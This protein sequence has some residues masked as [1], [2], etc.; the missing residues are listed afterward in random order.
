MSSEFEGYVANAVGWARAHLGSTEYSLRCLAFVEDAYECS[1][2]IE[3]FGG[4]TAAESAG[5]YRAGL[6]AGHAPPPGAFVFYECFGALRG[7]Y[8]DWGHVGLHVGHGQVI[9]AWDRVRQDHYLDVQQ[10]TPAPGWGKPRYIGWTPVERFLE[11]YRK[12]GGQEE[13]A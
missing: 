10:L 13:L 1:N 2:R 8:Q 12:K 5:E 9:H 6:N 7:D 11:G 4:S 3:L